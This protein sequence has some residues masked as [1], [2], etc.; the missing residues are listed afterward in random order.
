MVFTIFTPFVH[1]KLMDLEAQSN[2]IYERGPQKVHFMRKKS[3]I[4]VRK[5]LE[6]VW[7]NFSRG[8]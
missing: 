5:I 8:P 2:S 7:F 1:V 6:Y 4:Q 3:H